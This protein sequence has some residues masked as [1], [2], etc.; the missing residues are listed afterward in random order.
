MRENKMIPESKE[1][2]Q[3][4]EDADLKQHIAET[5]LNDLPD[6]FGLPDSTREYIEKSRE[7]PFFAYYMEDRYVGFIVLK[8]T[9]RY[10]AEIYVM[11]VLQ[12]YHRHGI[13]KKLFQEFLKYAEQKQYEFIQVKTVEE[14]HYEEYDRTRMF[15][16]RIGFKKLECFPSLWDE[17]NPCLVMIMSVKNEISKSD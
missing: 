17:W 5:I 14:G 13:G 1:G 11:G 7:M 8:E 15:Y 10:T 12:K 3:F 4:I 9:S 2:V 6:W 16:E